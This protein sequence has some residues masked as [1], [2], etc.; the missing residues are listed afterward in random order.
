[1]GQIIKERIIYNTSNKNTRLVYKWHAIYTRSKHEK[2]VYD[3]LQEQ[4]IESFLPLVRT[5]KQWSDRKKKVIEPLLKSYVFVKV[6]EKEYYDAVNTDGAVCYIRFEAKAAAIP[7]W[8]IDTLR[9]IIDSETSFQLTTNRYETGDHVIIKH[10]TMAGYQ[11]EVIR[12]SK[13]ERKLILRI[14]DLGFVL[15]LEVALD[16]VDKV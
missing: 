9:Q 1:M 14:G 6:S 15:E 7:E 2:K 8:Q 13:G 16:K 10:G 4:N 12:T 11:G 3:L 5:V